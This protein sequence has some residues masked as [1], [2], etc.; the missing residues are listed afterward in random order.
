M[1]NAFEWSKEKK[2]QLIS[3]KAFAQMFTYANS[4]PGKYLL[5]LDN[6]LW[7]SG[8]YKCLF[9]HNQ[10]KKPTN[11][12]CKHSV[13]SNCA[14]NS[15][16]GGNWSWNIVGCLSS[17]S[18]IEW[19]V[20]FRKIIF[21]AVKNFSRQLFYGEIRF[22]SQRALMSECIQIALFETI[23]ICVSAITWHL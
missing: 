8:F 12:S 10:Q 4:R 23:L 20:P 5:L 19:T 17:K 7:L 2:S 15:T 1:E 9:K 22:Y 13:I 11:L 14:V 16:P 6:L 18:W 3:H 21:I